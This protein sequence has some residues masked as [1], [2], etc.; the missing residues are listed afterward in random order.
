LPELAQFLKNPVE[1]FFTKGLLL[2]FEEQRDLQT[3]DETF[4]VDPLHQYS[5]ERLLIEQVIMPSQSHQALSTALASSLA[6]LKK[7]GEIGL[8]S[9]ASRVSQE[10]Y[11]NM[12][13]LGERFI[14]HV[15]NLRYIP[16]H[17]VDVYHSFAS[18]LNEEIQLE[19]SIAGFWQHQDPSIEP[20]TRV[21]IAQSKT[22]K[23]VNGKL[24][25][26]F[27]TLIPYWLEHVAGHLLTTPFVTDVLAKECNTF[28][29]FEGLSKEQALAIMN[30]IVKAWQN[31]LTYPLKLDSS[32]GCQ[33]AYA[34]FSGDVSSTVNAAVKA[35][36]GSLEYDKG[37]F[38]RAFGDDVDAREFVNSD[39]FMSLSK[40]VYLPMISA[41][42]IFEAES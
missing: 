9:T 32:A 41:V 3:D 13:F 7:S 40:Q 12:M 29:R 27:E 22:S 36:Q 30:D 23:E 38:V 24:L 37:Y 14:E 35:M 31:G 33:F 10:L 17:R 5:I 39:A 16:E 34:L 1:S 2:N 20:L 18:V 8:A 42:Q 25:R 28:Y 21:V 15:R 26:R 19:D 11:Q 4:I 6:H